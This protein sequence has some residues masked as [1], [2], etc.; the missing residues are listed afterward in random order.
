MQWPE[1]LDFCTH[2]PINLHRKCDMDVLFKTHMAS[3]S[4]LITYTEW[5][6]G[7]KNIVTPMNHRIDSSHSRKE[8]SKSS[9]CCKSFAQPLRSS[10]AHLSNARPCQNFLLVLRIRCCL[11]SAAILNRYSLATE[12]WSNHA[13]KSCHNLQGHRKGGPG[14]NFDSTRVHMSSELVGMPCFHWRICRYAVI[15]CPLIPASYNSDFGREYWLILRI[16]SIQIEL[17]LLGD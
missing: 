8:A 14:I 3:T 10:S 15:V 13:A 9:S 7:A 2:C 6:G 5:M 4:D 11:L 1:S 17:W 12:K 16:H